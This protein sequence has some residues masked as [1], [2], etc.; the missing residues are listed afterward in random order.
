ME[1]AEE[2]NLSGEVGSGKQKE[3]KESLLVYCVR[4]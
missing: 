1:E 4:N 2:Q 3:G